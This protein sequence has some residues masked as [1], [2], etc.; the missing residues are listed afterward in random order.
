[1]GPK[2]TISGCPVF[3]LTTLFQPG[4]SLKLGLEDLIKCVVPTVYLHD[5]L[6]ATDY[7]N[8]CEK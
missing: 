7:C 3:G 4:G 1:M 8:G 2:L 5:Y 6:I